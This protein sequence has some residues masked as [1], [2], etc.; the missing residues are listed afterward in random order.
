MNIMVFKN[1]NVAAFEKGQQV[2]GLQLSLASLL[3]E[4]IAKAGIEPDGITVETQWGVNW[5]LYKTDYGYKHECT[6]G[7]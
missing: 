4:H 5:R 6:K 7:D 2:P 3:A 1:G